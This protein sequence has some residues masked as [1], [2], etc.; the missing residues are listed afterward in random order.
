MCGA[1]STI[2]DTKGC[3]NYARYGIFCYSCRE[4]D[5]E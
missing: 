3:I 5:E 1:I 4:G 2:C